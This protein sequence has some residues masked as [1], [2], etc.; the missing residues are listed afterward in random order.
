MDL[1]FFFLVLTL[2]VI[3]LIMLFSSSYAYAYY[4]YGNSYYF[5]IRQAGFAVAGI[6]IMV[7]ISYFDYHHLHKLAI[8]I[9]L[10]TYMLLVLVLFMP[11][12]NGV[13]RWIYL[14]PVN[15]QP[16]EIAKFALVLIFA[17]L[18]SI[19]FKRM[20]T[21]RYGVLPYL[22]ILGSIAVLVLLEKHVS[23]TLILVAL[24]G[25]ML[26]IG[27][28]QLRWFAIAF[29]VLGAAVAYIVLI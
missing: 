17:H 2:M 23:A 8:P 27:G 1:P 19:N 14:G 9:L 24:A 4:N 3:G 28:V 18:I 7:A 12:R 10:V 29:G 15:F 6:F 26:F 21:F 5:I 25:V 20:S 13:R 11:E 22:L 16:S